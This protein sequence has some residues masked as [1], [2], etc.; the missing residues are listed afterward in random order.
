MATRS[1][2]IR[3][4]LERSTQ[5]PDFPTAAGT[6]VR[7]AH[8]RRLRPGRARDGV[9]GE[10]EVAADEVVRI[11]LD[12]GFVLWSRADAMVR[13]HG[14]RSLARDGGEAWEFDALR[15]SA[16]GR[17]EADE[18]GL[19]GLGIRLLDFFGVSLEEAA[20][21][22]LAKWFEEK[23]LAPHKPGLY[24]CR[25]DGDF[26][27][28]P[29]AA[30]AALPADKPL[31]IF[32]HGT[33]SSCEGSFGKLWSAD[34][35]AGREARGR[36]HGDYETRAFAFE[37]RSLSESPI[38]NALALVQRLPAGAELHLVS[39]S[40]G[41]LVGELLCLGQCERVLELLDELTLKTLFA[42]DRTIAE[43]LGLFPLAPED[44]T[45]RDAAY[46]GDR[47]AL[48]ELLELLVARRLRVTRFVRVACPA[49]GTTLASG[50]LDRWLSMLG[51]LADKAAGL[52]LFADG[53][54]FLLAVVKERTDP[55]TLP[56][57]E[58]MMPG[59]ALTRLLHHPELFSTAD[60][61]AIA[62]D[63]EGGS[64]WQKLKL[65]VADWFYGAEHD[66]VV[67]TGSMSGGL[68]RPDKGA[69]FRADKGEAVDHFSYFRNERSVGWLLA[70]LVRAD[71]ED[72]GFLPIGEASHAPP[73]WREAVERSQ[74][75]AAPRPLAVLL[76]GAMGSAL[77]AAG[78]AVWLDYR[79]LLRGGLGEIAIDAPEVAVG[80]PLDEFYGPL[81][82]FLAHSHHVEVFPYDWRRSVR[83]AAAKLAEA[84]EQW[85]PQA[86]RTGQA[87]HL[88]AH[89]MGG[90][91]ARAMIADGGRGAAVWQRI[92]ALP[93]SRLLML[94]TPNHG[95][96]EA[97]RWLTGLN[98]AQA[99]LALLDFSR[100]ASEIV[101][102]VRAYPGLLEL[103]PFADDAPDFADPARWQLIRDATQARWQPADAGALRD[104]HDT[105]SLL[106]AAAPDPDRMCCVAGSQPATVVGYQLADYDETSWLSGRKRLDFVASGAGDG[107]VSWASGRLERVGTWYVE[108][109][110]HDALCVQQRAFPAYL[111]LLQLGTTSRLPATPPPRLRAGGEAAESFL[112]P[113]LPPADHLPAEGD[114]HSLGFGGGIAA[115]AL[116]QRPPVPMIEVRIRHGDLSYARHPVLVGHYLGDTIVSAERTLDRQ[117]DGALS[118]RLQLGIYPGRLDTNALFFNR[119]RDTPPGGAIVVGLGQVGELSPGLLESGVRAAL[120]D[121]ALQV[122]Q[123]PNARFGPAGSPRRASVSCLLVGTGAGA[124]TVR[125]SLEAILRAALATNARLV[126]SE[127]DRRVS[128]DRIEFIEVFA[129][130]A[131]GAAEALSTILGNEEIAASVRWPA[132]VVESGR[133]GRARVRFDEAPEWWHRLEII[134]EKGQRNALRFIFPTDRARAEET[135]ASGQLALAEAFIR[136]ASR[137]ARANPEA[138]RTLY[139][140]LL[141]LRLKE[142]ARLQGDLVL[143]VD[144]RS[145]RYPWELLEDRWNDNGRPP[146]V[147]AGLV[148]QLK[149]AS[150]RPQPAHAVGTSALV[151]G[152]PDLGGWDRFDDLPGARSEAHKVAALLAER[153]WQ[154]RDC[155]DEPAEAVIENLHRDAWR[156]LHL[157]G[158]GEHD[159]PL[160]APAARPGGA[161]DEK[162]TQLVSGMI[163]GRDTFLTPGDIE[164]MR[165]VPELVFINCCHLGKSQSAGD[166]DRGALAANLGMQFIR[167]GVRA[168][169][170]AGWAVDDGAAL[171]FAEAF[172]RRMLDGEPFGEAVRAAREDIWLRFPGVNTWGAYQC[173]GDPAFSLVRNRAPTVRRHRPWRAPVELVVELDNL[174]QGLKASSEAAAGRDEATAERIAG[175]LERIPEAQRAQWLA[176]ADVAAA[177]GF[178][179]GEA[180][181][182]ESAIKQLE[183]ALRASKGNCPVRAIEQLANFRVRWAA[184]QWRARRERGTRESAAEAAAR[185]ALMQLGIADLEL[186]S[187]RA[188]TTERLDL[189]GSA[190]KRRALAADTPAARLAALEASAEAYRSAYEQGGRRESYPF[191]NW[192]SAMLLA[193]RLDDDRPTL[194]WAELEG[195]IAR[196]NEAL[197]KRYAEEPDFWDGAALADLELVRL[198]ARCVADAPA[199]GRRSRRSTLPRDCADIATAVRDAYRRVITRGASPRERASVIE[200]LD[201]LIG[202]L[203]TDLPALRKALM[204]IRDAL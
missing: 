32:L 64:L 39:H 36:L 181:F 48:A 49:R 169:V 190:W 60:L 143:L 194:P 30:D 161:T 1:Y 7:I 66:L 68:R 19:L 44:E 132:G 25:L 91:V 73:R 188:A 139:E 124:L 158:H 164:Q 123:W 104:A 63:V 170:A 24:R 67:N 3:G 50:R 13:E 8:R 28:S 88:V 131:L 126:A 6:G 162:P 72:G 201:C 23:Q 138:A 40:R 97:L 165:W 43:Q 20:A 187:R 168:V 10:H 77:H 129:D 90:L 198:L 74:R 37:H 29:L 189:L 173:Y 113:P 159:Y 150:F 98:P 87:V 140:M 42:A 204:E 59:S 101:D 153:D 183:N 89:S 12:N 83:E 166:S 130:V 57:L 16:A 93:G 105:W 108:D 156:I 56:G 141:P 144:D 155:I 106:R 61:S 177:L 142:A 122:S 58:A 151:V 54:D 86:E 146:A 75:S 84:L 18:R 41:G 14:R 111:E 94:G 100:S 85:L 118:R 4:E 127:L 79:A 182:W 192:V 9:T 137:S 176:R 70:G 51:F 184:E 26:A 22:N 31:L 112:L 175:L 145:A 33:A 180:R 167:M 110:A 76:P 78:K 185:E 178:A 154:V 148:R 96:W 52:D 179:W 81:L 196:L 200:N 80:R 103:L 5:A 135:L 2:R 171:A 172:Y 117:L 174:A 62:G 115:R 45:A 71:H 17:A 38:A 119:R 160:P 11:E 102:L 35:R 121:Y 197:R 202:L 114:L 21:K 186:L 65:L 69:R 157:A 149:T 15:P 203:D 107:T 193:Q 46:D 191:T 125:D 147:N 128:L 116:D 55:R 199:A 109:T 120:L 133:A 27:L 82:E 163:I 34:N 47:A 136:A 195:D 53:L 92:A 99:R 95:S 152:N 134:E